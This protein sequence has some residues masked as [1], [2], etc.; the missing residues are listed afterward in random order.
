MKLKSIKLEKPDNS[1]SH[2]KDSEFLA[3]QR[4]EEKI[5][6]NYLKKGESISKQIINSLLK[7]KLIEMEDLEEE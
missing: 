6:K 1:P 2:K 5:S 7:S 3:K 4:K